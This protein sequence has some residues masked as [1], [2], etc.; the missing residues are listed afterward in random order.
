MKAKGRGKKIFVFLPGPRYYI[1]PKRATL[2]REQKGCETSHSQ[3]WSKASLKWEVHPHPKASILHTEGDV[4]TGNT[5]PPVPLRH[6]ALTL[7]VGHLVYRL[8]PS[9]SPTAEV[10]SRC[11]QEHEDKGNVHIEGPDPG[12]L[13]DY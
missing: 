13:S 12:T 9:K 4:W 11:Q 7:K 2:T 6:P 10:K 5:S 3:L 1:D 8:V